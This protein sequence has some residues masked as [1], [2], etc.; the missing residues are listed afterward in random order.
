MGLLFTRADRP[1]LA[2][3]DSGGAGTPVLALHGTFGRGAVFARL[4]TD[5]AGRARVVAPDQR[6]HGHSGRAADYGRDEFVA[7]AADLL[8]HLDLGPA[9]VLGHSSGG[10]TAYQLAARRPD[11]VSAL[12]VE[13]VG[14]VMGPPEVPHPVLD[15]RG[16]PTSAPT[17]EGLARA[18]GAH[19]P[20]SAYFLA[21]AVE[22]GSGW[23]LLFDWDDMMAVQE[24]CVG[25]W[26]PDWLGS[27]CPALVL[28]GGRSP[29]LPG[30][31][32]RDMV[33]RR[34]G[35]RLVEFPEAGHWI[36]DDDP[37]G[38]ARA[39]GDFLRNIRLRTTPA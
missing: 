36:H 21:S 28:H 9:V 39:V 5:L 10:I 34:P 33:A 17:R 13:D 23:R 31:L 6:G 37:A 12:V 11:L 22:D 16:R 20:D 18:I 38:F 30:P 7:D 24:G 29:L 32:A 1:T 8:D 2:Y 4:A 14:P 26:W 3:T 15:V 19:V 25:D 35:A 27:T